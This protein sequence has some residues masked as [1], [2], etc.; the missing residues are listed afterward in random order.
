MARVVV[1]DGLEAVKLAEQFLILMAHA[2]DKDG[3][4]VIVGPTQQGFQDD[5][6]FRRVGDLLKAAMV[7]YVGPDWKLELK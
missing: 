3:L 2:K 1:L 4:R 7:E 5:T 6:K